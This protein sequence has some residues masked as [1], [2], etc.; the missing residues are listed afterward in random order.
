MY[1]KV[2]H[3]RSSLEHSSTES[4]ICQGSVNPLCVVHLRRLRPLLLLK[5]IDVVV[6][7]NLQLILCDPP[8]HLFELPCNSV[9][10]KIT[11]VNAT[12]QVEEL[13]IK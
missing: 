2:S 11:A 12:C 10:R 6:T 1:F 4:S 8:I 9:N 3:S 5:G 13:L 7:L